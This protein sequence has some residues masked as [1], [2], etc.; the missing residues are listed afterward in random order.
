MME[1]GLYLLRF[2]WAGVDYARKVLVDGGGYYR[3]VDEFDKPLPDSLPVSVAVTVANGSHFVPLCRIDPNDE[4]I[5][6]NDANETT[7]DDGINVLI[8]C[9]HLSEPTWIAYLEDNTW[10]FIDG[11]QVGE[12]VSF[13]SDMPLGPAEEDDK[14]NG[15]TADLPPRQPLLGNSVAMA[16]SGVSGIGFVEGLRHG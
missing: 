5:H 6:W 11:S 12:D 7:P 3:F 10:H 4:N 9:P 8:K 14:T 15:V 13:W 2:R 1:Q 16:T